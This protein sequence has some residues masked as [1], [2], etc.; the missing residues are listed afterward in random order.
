MASAIF[1]DFQLFYFLIGIIPDLVSD[2]ILI[3]IFWELQISLWLEMLLIWQSQHCTRPQQKFVST[4]L[5][6]GVDLETVVDDITK[7]PCTSGSLDNKV[8]Q[9]M[10]PGQISDRLLILSQN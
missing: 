10:I 7:I 9:W 5:E 6:E 1:I 8:I 2:L 3:Q 4:I